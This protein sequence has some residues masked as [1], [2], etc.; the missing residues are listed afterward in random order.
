MFKKIPRYFLLFEDEGKE[1]KKF[2]FDLKKLKDYFKKSNISDE[3]KK[4]ASEVLANIFS[5]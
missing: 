5:E 1:L 4:I 3:E 2:N